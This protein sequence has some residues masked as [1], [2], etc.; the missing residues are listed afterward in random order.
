M[1]LTSASRTAKAKDHR[2]FHDVASVVMALEPSYPVFCL[3]PEVI[4]ENARRFMS[5]FPGTVLYAVK[6]NP[7]PMVL[8]VLYRAGIR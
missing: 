3:R 7:H 5:L 1:E 2:S 8:D 6:C 4:E